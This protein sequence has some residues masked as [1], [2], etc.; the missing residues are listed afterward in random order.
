[1]PHEE[2]PE[3]VK[4]L[5]GVKKLDAEAGPTVYGGD[6]DEAGARKVIAPAHRG[7]ARG[8][9]AKVWVGP[10]GKVQKYAIAVR[11]QGTLGNAEIDGTTEKSVTLSGQGKTRVEPPA[12]AVKSLE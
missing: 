11:L 1:L 2:L 6:L 3:L 8:G 9:K 12:E 4:L 10:D 7:V 5:R